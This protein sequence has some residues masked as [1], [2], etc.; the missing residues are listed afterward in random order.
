MESVNV[1]LTLFSVYFS[2]VGLYHSLIFFPQKSEPDRLL[3]EVL[4]TNFL[5]LLGVFA[6]FKSLERV[7]KSKDIFAPNHTGRRAVWRVSDCSE[8]FST[9]T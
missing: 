9:Y 8:S 6:Y 3:Y 5:L 4:A 1:S 2:H 7:I